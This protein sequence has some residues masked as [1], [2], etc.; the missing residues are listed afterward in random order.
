MAFFFHS[1][2]HTFFDLGW[3]PAPVRVFINWICGHCV[4]LRLFFLA[5]LPVSFLLNFAFSLCLPLSFV[6]IILFLF[7]FIF[8]CVMM[9][10]SCLRAIG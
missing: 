9:T 7:T 3:G 6:S 5:S 10:R 2:L 4:V 8:P 1:A